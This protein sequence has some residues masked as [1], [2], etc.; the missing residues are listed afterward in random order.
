M[1]LEEK[2]ANLFMGMGLP[3]V[4]CPACSKTFSNFLYYKTMGWP[5]CSVRCSCGKTIFLPSRIISIS[6]FLWV[7][8]CS[9]IGIGGI[10][11]LLLFFPKPLNTVIGIIVV[12]TALIVGGFISSQVILHWIAKQTK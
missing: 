11:I 2:V 7:F 10:Q 12:I 8:I 1:G 9:L 4:N 6:H 3:K 5:L